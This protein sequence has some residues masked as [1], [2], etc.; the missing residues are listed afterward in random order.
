MVMVLQMTALRREKQ[1][2]LASRAVHVDIDIKAKT[3]I[4]VAF[5]GTTK[6]L[7]KTIIAQYVESCRKGTI[8]EIAKQ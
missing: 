3:C 4:H 6:T 7:L 1:A 5:A 2:N 8:I